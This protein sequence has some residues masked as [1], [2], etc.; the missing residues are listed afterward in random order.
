MSEPGFEV[1]VDA[2]HREAG[3]W[4]E[5]AAAI[6]TVAARAETLRLSYLT[7]GIFG[8]IVADYEA[9]VDQVTGRCGEGSASMTSIAE[10]L[11]KNADAYEATDH[12]VSARIRGAY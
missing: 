8:L 3:V 4:D 11:R 7:A 2:L 1:V 5:Q 10:R 12:D 6:G 9:A